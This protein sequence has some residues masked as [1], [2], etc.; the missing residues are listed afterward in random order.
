[1]PNNTHFLQ[2]YIKNP[3]DT[4]K[5]GEI[6][7]RGNYDICNAKLADILADGI[8]R[9]KSVLKKEFEIYQIKGGEENRDIRFQPFADLIESG[10]R[11]DFANYEKV[12]E[13][14]M[15]AVSCVSDDLR[16]KL[17]GIFQK[18]NIDRPDDF[19]GHSLSVSD[20]VVL[21]EKAYYVDSFGFQ[22]L[23]EFKPAAKNIDREKAA[24]VPE[25]EKTKP[26]K[27]PKL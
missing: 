5:V 22:P 2:E 8:S 19:K 27:K 18:F 25:Q 17:E 24:P 20:V 14:G 7:C 3:D 11:P 10:G 15:D 13:G 12:Y 21:N 26:P 6:I 23:K 9:E 1:M 4:Y 16:D